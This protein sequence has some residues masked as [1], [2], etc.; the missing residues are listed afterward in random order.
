[1]KILIKESQYRLLV[2][3]ALPKGYKTFTPSQITKIPVSNKDISQANK[4]DIYNTRQKFTDSTTV[5]Y[6]GVD[7]RQKTTG[8]SQVV[9]KIQP[10]DT[11]TYLMVLQVGTAFIPV[12]GPFISAGIGLYSAAKL[13]DEGKKA[14]A[15][16][17]A[18][19][20]ILPGLSRVVQKIPGIT[21]LG[22]K[23]MEALGAKIAAKQG[24]TVVEQD[25]AN[26]I[27]ENEPLIQAEANQSIKSM[28]S[29]AL[30]KVA[31]NAK[32]SIKGIAEKGLEHGIQHGLKQAAASLDT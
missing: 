10:A 27:A 19:F 8:T 22:E 21:Q 15:G 31:P 13:Y 6:K 11:E 17:V 28:A 23:G 24:L 12:I 25:V 3:Q 32:K 26:A 2:E 1:M 14:E 4:D 18:L 20:S 29:K 16:V 9:R 7:G 30:N 5:A